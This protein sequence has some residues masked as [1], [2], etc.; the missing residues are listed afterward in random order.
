M[1]SD[2]HNDE[3]VKAMKT[4]NRTTDLA[5]METSRGDA[6]PVLQAIEPEKP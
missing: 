3:N 1:A 6:V 2:A 5:A 4:P